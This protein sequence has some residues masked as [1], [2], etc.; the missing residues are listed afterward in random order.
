MAN[1]HHMQIPPHVMPLCFNPQLQQVN[2]QQMISSL[3]NTTSI[4][5]KNTTETKPECNKNGFTTVHRSRPYKGRSNEYYFFGEKFICCPNGRGQCEPLS[6]VH[7]NQMRNDI[8]NL[9]NSIT[10]K[11]TTIELRKTPTSNNQME[12][13][14]RRKCENQDQCP[15]EYYIFRSNGYFGYYKTQDTHHFHIDKVALKRQKLSSPVRKEILRGGNPNEIM[16]QAIMDGKKASHLFGREALL[17]KDVKQTYHISVDCSFPKDDGSY[18]QNA[19]C[20][21]PYYK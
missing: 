3:Q 4:K 20:S 16:A 8:L 6:D 2:N 19:P 1:L 18:L 12:L 9:D 10:V 5:R 11:R 13:V 7:Y 21:D 15:I 17:V 14:G